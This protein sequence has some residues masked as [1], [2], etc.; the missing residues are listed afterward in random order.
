MKKLLPQQFQTGKYAVAG[1][2]IA[3]LVGLWVS[4]PLTDKNSEPSPANM[5]G[6]AVDLRS[7][8]EDFSQYGQ[9]SEKSAAGSSLYNAGL[10]G[11]IQFEEAPGTPSR[12]DIPAVAPQPAAAGGG[13]AAYGASGAGGG[14]G[15]A[16]KRLSMMPSIGG[17]GGSSSG[18]KLM[19]AS[20]GGGV[21]KQGGAE[22]RPQSPLAGRSG[23]S[24]S[25]AADGAAAM[26]G[27]NTSGGHKIT[28]QP[29]SAKNQPP[30]R[31]AGGPAY[32]RQS[33]QQA[34]ETAPYQNTSGAAGQLSSK[35]GPMSGGGAPGGQASYG[36]GA[37]G[38]VKQGVAKPGGHN[39]QASGE[40]FAAHSPVRG[41]ESAPARN[42]AAQ[43]ASGQTQPQQQGR[44]AASAARQSA[45]AESSDRGAPRAALAAGTATRSQTLYDA[46]GQ[47]GR[48]GQPAGGQSSQAGANA[49]ARTGPARNE[50]SPAQA[51]LQQLRAG[52]QP[53][54]G[55]GRQPE[56][57]SFFGA[58]ETKS[59]AHPDKGPVS[60]SRPDSKP[61]DRQGGKAMDA[62]VQGNKSSQTA[63]SS[64]SEE[65]ARSKAQSAFDK[66]PQHF[67]DGMEASAQQAGQIF[68][69]TGGQLQSMVPNSDM[70]GTKEISYPTPPTIST[71]TPPPASEPQES[72]QQKLV[73]EI[74][75][76]IVKMAMGAILGNDGIFGDTNQQQQDMNSGVNS[77]KYS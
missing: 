49:L 59:A 13:S 51:P 14:A 57:K 20:M 39:A 69:S 70:M 17:S 18:G 37:Q 8:G 16:A 9:S 60:G 11:G 52:G 7:L 53:S 33:G 3:V 68:S 32:G 62:L 58:G 21:S 45:P 27:A 34:R 35:Q 6:R 50:Y 24:V 10:S 22:L 54:A 15:G 56:A 72:P 12:V 42:F 2:I 44:Q 46:A 76:M 28:T 31:E 19:G 66:M 40:S 73:N 25:S 26:R 30:L 61:E 41:G 77:G 64:R 55:D 23:A 74:I 71:P 65:D 1:I 63:A 48:A 67:K 4:L 29:A 47:P 5:R 75:L 38:G 36:A 43:G